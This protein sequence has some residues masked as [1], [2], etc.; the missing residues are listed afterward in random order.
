M[1]RH[2]TAPAV[3]REGLNDLLLKCTERSTRQNQP[4]IFDS[5]NVT[6]PLL[7]LLPNLNVQ[8]MQGSTTLILLR[9]ACIA[10]RP[11]TGIDFRAEADLPLLPT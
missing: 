9:S 3:P 10:L 4:R 7:G 1:G 8:D 5:A 2:K 6:K 11:R